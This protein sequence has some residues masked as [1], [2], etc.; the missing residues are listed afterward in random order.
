LAFCFAVACHVV[1]VVRYVNASFGKAGIIMNLV[2]FARGPILIPV[3]PSV[4][5][6]TEK[7]VRFRY[8]FITVI[9]AVTVSGSLIGLEH[10]EDLKRVRR[11]VLGP[12]HAPGEERR[13]HGDSGEVEGS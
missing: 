6:V 9:T 13:V 7:A 1:V 5:H 4:A 12:Q 2:A 10:V 3:D 8:R 11:V